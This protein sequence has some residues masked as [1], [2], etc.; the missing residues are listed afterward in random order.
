MWRDKLVISPVLVGRDATLDSLDHLLEQSAHGS[1]RTVLL[2][3][4]AGLGKSRLVAETIRRAVLCDIQVL[5]GNCFETDRTV[6]Y[7]PLLDLL[8]FFCSNHSPGEIIQALAAI[9][10]PLVRI[11]PDLTSYFP[12][13]IPAPWLP[14]EQQKRRIFQALANFFETQSKPALLL[15]IEDLHWSNDTSLEFL[16]MLARRIPA[17]PIL[18]LLTYRSDEV[19]PPLAHFLA[20][21]DRERLA[22]E[23]ALQPLSPDQVDTMLRAIFD[24]KRPVRKEFLNVLYALTEGNPF[25]TEEVL[26]ALITSGEIYYADGEW[27]RK[28]I[29]EL[30]IPRTVRDAVQRRTAQLDPAAWQVLAFAAVAGHRFEVPL[31]Q[32]L[33]G[34]NEPQLLPL[35]K[36]LI[37]AQLL[38]EES[39]DE[40]A[41]RH[42][43]TREAVYKSLL[44]RERKAMH[45]QVAETL[46]RGH[47]HALEPFVADLAFHYHAAQ[48]WDK[49]LEYAQR[50][51]DKAA[52]IYAPRE[53]IEHYTHAVEAAQ[54]LGSAPSLELYRARASAYQT[55]GEFDRARVDYEAALETART[56]QEPAQ[57]WQSLLD[58]GALWAA[59]DYEMTGEYYQSAYELARTI[60]EPRALA[61]T[62]NRL[63]NWYA[64]KG[65][66]NAARRHHQEALNLF[67]S[68]QDRQGLAETF[69]LL[70][71]TNIIGGDL[72][73]SQTY[74][75]QAIE[76]FRALDNRQGLASALASMVIG[77]GSFP[78]TTALWVPSNQTETVHWG[79]EAVNIAREIGWRA[80]EAYAL[81]ILASHFG[82]KGDYARAFPNALAGLAIANEI[83]HAQWMTLARVHF[84]ALA[85]D[86]FALSDARAALEAALEL[87]NQIGSHF[88]I[89]QASGFLARTYLAEH[90][91][92]RAET[93]LAAALNR[94]G[95]SPRSD[96][97]TVAQS[98][99]AFENANRTNAPAIHAATLAQRMCWS[100]YAEFALARDDPE[101]ALSIVD[102]LSASAAKDSS[103]SVIP[104]LAKLRG[105]ALLALNQTEEAERALL[106]ARA[107]AQGQGER[108]L[109]WRI[110][111]A[112]G[113]LYQRTR[114]RAQA[115]G[116][117]AA[118]Q[119][120][121]SEL[122]L[123]IPDANVRENFL[124]R[125]RAGMPEPRAPSPRQLAKREFGGLTLREREVV[126]GIA[127][128][129][130]NREIGEALFLSER[131][132]ETH[133]GNVLTK[134]G[135]AARAQI[136]AW[137]VEKGLVKL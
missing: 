114:R 25:F 50:A 45:Q 62:L 34:M 23:L 104:R 7:A 78:S 47:A 111:I 117:F 38:V 40:F 15:V 79:E 11:L 69:D 29:H 96:L 4:E 74:Y 106:S 42:A 121:V 36:Q 95:D 107:A 3:G 70:G 100:A 14:P 135:F 32:R 89:L 19:H 5:A 27:D 48:I 10:P 2:A 126:A 101:N 55:L 84:G 66:P 18:L 88:W 53:A 127:Q 71:M 76:N 115:A 110:D 116:S 35:L 37:G 112:L 134:L 1:G 93:T 124:R 6:P 54:E 80:G 39:V 129:K 17:Q 49:T 91:L 133:V 52:S 21:L 8:R 137:A 131:T 43:L 109:L 118:A 119:T 86:V 125:A 83:E 90:E 9:A 99:V 92:A 94:T 108:P 59:R 12:D 63:G 75:A 44:R 72:I 24:L 128:G 132:I 105:E 56:R 123:G 22:L 16:L 58:L 60:N 68:L 33:T 30:D 122:A 41:F 64:N 81:V 77:N 73:T 65:D 113:K 82:V 61:H 28:P 97:H 87:A 67:H 46:E 20:Q 26:K 51:G 13:H 98:T 85:L 57:E 120:M 31:L 102:V 130:S 103:T 136:A